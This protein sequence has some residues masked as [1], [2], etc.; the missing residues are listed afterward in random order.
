MPRSTHQKESRV[1]TAVI[2]LNLQDGKAALERVR[3]AAGLPKE[4][5]LILVAFGGEFRLNGAEDFSHSLF[6]RWE[7]GS[8]DNVVVSNGISFFEGLTGQSLVCASARLVKSGGVLVV[9]HAAPGSG[10]PELHLRH[11]RLDG[12]IGQRGERIESFSR[13]V[14]R[15]RPSPRPST[16]GWYVDRASDLMLADMAL[17]DMSIEELYAFLTDLNMQTVS[18]G[19]GSDFYANQPEEIGARSGALGDQFTV[20]EHIQKSLKFWT[21]ALGGLAYKSP[22]LTAI[23]RLCEIKDGAHLIDLGGAFGSAAAEAVLDPEN[24]ISSSVTVDLLPANAYFAD[25]MHRELGESL[26]GR[27]THVVGKIDLYEPEPCDVVSAFGSLLYLPREEFAPSLD[28]MWEALRPGG[29]LVLHENLRD[30]S[31]TYRDHQYMFLPDE[32]KGYMDRYGTVEFFDTMRMRT[33]PA[34]T[35]GD[36]SVFRYVRKT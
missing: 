17:R 29:V 28:R 2:A 27:A 7:E 14:I 19:A 16:L 23:C 21:Y 5:A 4:R 33:L 3:E 30:E 13:Y 20:R 11:G 6:D 31:E 36:Q 8:F 12:L 24:P 32:L 25:R 34:Q 22:A 18:L 35:A 15:R 9:P 1:T 10:A 26:R